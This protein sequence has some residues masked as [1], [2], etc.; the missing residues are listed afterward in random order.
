MPHT[1]QHFPESLENLNLNR[2]FDVLRDVGGDIEGIKEFTRRQRSGQN[3]RETPFLEF[4]NDP[5]TIQLLQEGYPQLFEEFQ[6]IS[7]EGLLSPADMNAALGRFREA[8]APQVAQQRARLAGG[9]SRRLGSRGTSGAAAGAIFNRADVPAMQFETQF[10]NQLFQKNLQSRQLGLQGRQTLLGGLVGAQEAGTGVELNLF[11]IQEQ[12]R[13]QR[14]QIEAENAYGIGDFI[15]DV[16]RGT[17]AYF[18]GGGSEVARQGFR[19][20]GDISR[21]FGR[22]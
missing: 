4:L 22:R 18:T 12:A 21:G 8:I 3:V 16:G 14:E 15:G 17:A 20:T 2:P 7:R 11:Q 1:A 6:R 19:S 9:V 13:L 5:E 10:A